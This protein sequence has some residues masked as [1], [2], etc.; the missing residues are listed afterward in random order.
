MAYALDINGASKV[1]IIGRREERLKETAA[2]AIS[3][4][5]IPVMGDVT[6][7]ES[8]QAAYDIISSQTDHV[9]LVVANSGTA[10]RPY[11]SS[12]PK[13]DGSMPP[14][15]ELR[16]HLWS[17]PMEEF[18]N[19]S[20]VNVT[21]A[22]Y[23][24][25]AFLPLL[26][27]ANKKRSAPEQYIVSPPR[28]Q[29]IITS[30]IAG[31]SRFAPGDMS[32]NFSKVAVNHMVKLLATTLVQDDI[33]VNGIAPGLYYTDM[34]LSFYESQ[35]VHGKGIMDGSFS[36][37]L[38]PITRSGSEEDI[39]GVILYMAGVAGGYLNGCIVVSD[40]GSLS[41]FPSTY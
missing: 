19:V 2:S 13:P 24:I 1:F 32:Y 8:L 15:S 9:D 41:I 39:A 23:T 7:K 40:G 36:R 21:G 33:R 20:H 28:P 31:F 12:E 10:G 29:I 25:L 3:G 6:S 4:S 14:F 5:I 35:G 16:N 18:T 11:A 38:I 37:D 26:K 27:A 22:F 30:S 17:I 34:T